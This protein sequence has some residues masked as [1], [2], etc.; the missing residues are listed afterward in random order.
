MTSAPAGAGNAEGARGE[1]TNGGG[2]GGEMGGGG[3]D[4]QAEVNVERVAAALGM[5]R[6]SS[7][8]GLARPGSP[9]PS[10]EALTELTDGGSVEGGG[11][12]ARGRA[13]GTGG[14][15]NGDRC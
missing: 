9:T 11:R 12:Q 7:A 13:G 5:E 3:S 2:G 10:L 4:P 8:L 6:V 1:E 14:H 15:L